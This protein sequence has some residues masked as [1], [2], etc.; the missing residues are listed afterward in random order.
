MQKESLYQ[1]PDLARAYWPRPWPENVNVPEQ[2]DAEEE[3]QTALDYPARE[4]LT[5]PW[6]GL[7]TAVIGGGL[8][9]VAILTVLTI[10]APWV[11]RCYFQMR[12]C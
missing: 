9:V 12:G 1:W 11:G 6:I 7:A 10:V 4:V 5:F 2:T 3:T 8:V